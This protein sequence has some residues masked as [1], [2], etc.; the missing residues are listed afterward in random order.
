M[1]LYRAAVP[2]SAKRAI[3]EVALHAQSV[4]QE[5]PV[6]LGHLSALP[7]QGLP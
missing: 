2:A 4:Q 5:H 6:Q 7:V 3:M 1:R